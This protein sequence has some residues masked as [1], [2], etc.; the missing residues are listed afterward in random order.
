MALLF[1]SKKVENDLRKID[2]KASKRILEKIEKICLEPDVLKHAR[3]L[4]GE[5]DGFYRFRVGD[6]RVV[7]LYFKIKNQETVLVHKIKHRKE[8]YK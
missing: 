3:K 4:E 1:Y 7:F 8:A 6:Y 2:S 5:L